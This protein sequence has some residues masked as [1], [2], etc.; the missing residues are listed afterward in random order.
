MHPVRVA[1]TVSKARSTR[2]RS[3]SSSVSTDQS[4]FLSPLDTPFCAS[5]HVFCGIKS[6]R[7]CQSFF[8]LRRDK[9]IADP[10]D[11]SIVRLT[12]LEFCM[13]VS[14]FELSAVSVCHTYSSPLRLSHCSSLS[15]CI[16]IPHPDGVFIG[17]LVEAI[18]L[19]TCWL[20]SPP[21]LAI[22]PRLTPYPYPRSLT[23]CVRIPQALVE[24]WGAW[25][26]CFLLVKVE[27]NYF[28]QANF[29]KKSWNNCNYRHYP[30]KMSFVILRLVSVPPSY[31]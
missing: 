28:L 30:D 21:L 20:L 2:V 5:F 29:F 25:G 14:L 12:S 27:H 17:L 4:L 22:T 31:F 1:R 23:K 9:I 8:A 10:L 18:H 6:H 3:C 11:H 24:R 16:H 15:C 26:A 13:F 7:P 19:F